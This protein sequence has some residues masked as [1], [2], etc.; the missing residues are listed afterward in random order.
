MH[1]FSTNAHDVV[2]CGPAFKSMEEQNTDTNMLQFF[3]QFDA[4][5]FNF[6]GWCVK[7][8]SNA[9]V[10]RTKPKQQLERR[11]DSKK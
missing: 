6:T 10:F 11:D 2:M 7:V 1:K 3:E 8:R 9:S 5:P 4:V